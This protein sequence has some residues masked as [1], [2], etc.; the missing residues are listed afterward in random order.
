MANLKSSIKDIR[1]TEKRTVFNK[2]LK[3]RVKS[4]KKEIFTAIEKGEI[5]QAAKMLPHFQKVTDKAA[6]NGILK[7]NTASRMKA[8]TAVKLNKATAKNATTNNS[9]S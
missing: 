2:R 9:G 7:K 1:R 6:K 5:E 4:A 8:R 3:E